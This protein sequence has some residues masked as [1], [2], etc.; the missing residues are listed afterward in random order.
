VQGTT[1]VAELAVDFN[2]LIASVAHELAERQRA[3]DEIRT[4][5]ADLE[6]RVSLR[7]EQLTA[8]NQE[9]EAFSYSVAHDLRAPLRAVDG[10]TAIV[11]EEHTA[12]LSDAARGYLDMVREGTRQMAALITDLLEFARL[13]RAEI[14]T[15]TVDL[16]P[17]V[18]EAVLALRSEFPGRDVD[19]TIGSLPRCRGDQAL[20]ERV[21]VNLLSNAFKYTGRKDTA[22]IVV[23]AE[24]N[25]E[26]G[27]VIYFVKDN[28][29]G[30]DASHASKLFGVFQRLH[31]AEDY[32]GTGIGLAIVQRIVRRH[33]GT[34]WAESEP[35]LGAKFSFTLGEVA[36]D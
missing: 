6:A 15:Q 27:E 26:S 29:V 24:L 36:D 1:E 13:S 25:R 9:L 10:F 34:V 18:E 23:G 35:E 30:F 11:I 5:N 22:E 19:V 20:L 2:V 17:L 32:P 4:L 21:V 8:A 31:R 3:E 7:T 16:V 12:E 14:H 28:G 33:G